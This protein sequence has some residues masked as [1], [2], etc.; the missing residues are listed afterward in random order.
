MNKVSLIGRLTKD[1][2]L[3]KTTNGTSVASYTIAVNEGYGEKQYTVFINITTW[4]KSAEFVEKYFKKG[5][6]IALI[7]R[8]VNNDYTDKNG[9]NVHTLQVV[10]E[11][12]EFVD[13]K[14]NENIESEKEEPSVDKLYQ[15]DIFISDD[16]LPF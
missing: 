11:D 14:T 5:N 3:R 4:N 15:D 7:G 13:N 1:P 12:I 9:N 2:E 16:D 10:T 8:L 6:K